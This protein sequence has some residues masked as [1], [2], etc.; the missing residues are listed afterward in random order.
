MGTHRAAASVQSPWVSPPGNPPGWASC[1]G[2]G[3]RSCACAGA[4]QH[5]PPR[6]HGRRRL[7]GC[8]LHLLPPTPPPAA[9]LTCA[10]PRGAHPE[11]KVSVRARAQADPTWAASLQHGVQLVRQVIEHAADVVQDA[12]CALL[13]RRR[14]AGGGRIMSGV[15]WVEPA[16]NTHPDLAL[17]PTL[18]ETK[19]SL[20]NCGCGHPKT[21]PTWYGPLPALDSTLYVASDRPRWS[22]NPVHVSPHQQCR[23]ETTSDH[24][25]KILATLL[26]LP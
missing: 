12:A 3:G 14:R 10:S 23:E 6:P 16:K 24:S 2:P 18:P 8:P 22:V 7:A 4:G 17:C 5:D 21:T 25:L 13:L 15:G 9:L 1:L 19:C 26:T 11:V 20:I